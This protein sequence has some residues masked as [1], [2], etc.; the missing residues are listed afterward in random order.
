MYRILT[1]HNIDRRG[2]EVLE[3]EGFE[4]SVDMTDYQAMLLKGR[5]IKD[6]PLGEELLAIARA[7]AHPTNVPV[8]ECN[9]AGIVVF[10]TP[11][12]NA[13]AVKE[14]TLASLILSGRDLPS[15]HPF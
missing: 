15:V 13:N 8:S 5:D 11:G 1:T 6:M 12:A 3:R 14:L 9:E 2:L 10:Y 4:Y 7:G